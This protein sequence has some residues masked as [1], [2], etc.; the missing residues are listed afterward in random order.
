MG[1]EA[2]KHRTDQLDFEVCQSSLHAIQTGR[3]PNWTRP[4]VSSS[5]PRKAGVKAPDF[6]NLQEIEHGAVA[7]T[8]RSKGTPYERG[9]IRHDMRRDE[10]DVLVVQSQR[11][12][13]IVA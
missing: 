3:S 11:F 6:V 13:G 12:I 2:G 7:S 5:L 10:D 1:E 8:S 4:D 9:A